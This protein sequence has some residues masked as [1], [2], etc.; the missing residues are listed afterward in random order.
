LTTVAEMNKQIQAQRENTY[1]ATLFTIDGK[2]E[3]VRQI[4]RGKVRQ[5]TKEFS[6]KLLSGEVR[7]FYFV[8]EGGE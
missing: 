5:R 1:F 7:A 3:G 6:D 8:V 4:H 2:L